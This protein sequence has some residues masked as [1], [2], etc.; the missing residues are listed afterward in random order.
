MLEKY[1]YSCQECGWNKINPYTN[2]TP[3]EIH[4]KD[5]NYL[6]GSEDNLALL[7]PNCHSLTD[8]YKALNRPKAR[9]DRAK[10]NQR[11]NPFLDELNY[12]EKEKKKYFCPICGKEITQKAKLCLDCRRKENWKKSKRPSKEELIFEFQKMPIFTRLGIK[13]G[14]SDNTIRHWMKS[15][16]IDYKSLSSK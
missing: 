11:P 7:C 8:T 13:Y 16:N 10:Y 2:K 6:N 9:R 1:N 3:L 15:Y 12:I 4:H 5:G 14:V